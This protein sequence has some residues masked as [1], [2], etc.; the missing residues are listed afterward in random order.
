MAAYYGALRLGATFTV[1]NPMFRAHEVAWQIAHAEPTVV[2]A[3]PEFADARG[4]RAAGGR[5]ARSRAGRATRHGAGLRGR[6]ER[7]GDAGLHLGHHRDTQGRADHPPQLPDLHGARLE[8]GA[9]DRPGRHLALRHAVPHHRG[10]RLDDHADAAGRHARAARDR[11]PRGDP[12]DPRPGAGHRPRAD[13]DVLPRAGRSARV[14]P[15]G[16]R[17]GAPLHDLRRAGG[18][19]ARSRPGRRRRRTRCGAPTGGS[20]SCRSWAPSAG[21]LASTTSPATATLRGS[22]SR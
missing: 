15:G 16:G 5:P 18:A 3:D 11:R 1:V 6:R 13:A 8:P 17:G 9:R 19:R 21:S 2:L 22:A 20:P 10:A 14:R 4:R 12:A 7:R